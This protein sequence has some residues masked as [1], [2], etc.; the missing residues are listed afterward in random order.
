MRE[1]RQ[2][3]LSEQ[4]SNLE[5]TEHP[6][7]VRMQGIGGGEPILVNTRIS[8]RL[9]AEC[10][11]AGMT[12]EEILRDYPHLN[13]AAVYD[14]ISYY[15]DHQEEIEEI[16]KANRIDTVLQQRGLLLDND[17]VIRSSNQDQTNR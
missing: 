2:D 3:T 1:F 8:V 4:Q 16:I 6:H 15:I 9:I 13:A 7:I 14:A 12:V 11:R 17:G 5:Q 10:Y